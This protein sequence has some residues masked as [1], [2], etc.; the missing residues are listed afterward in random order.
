MSLDEMLEVVAK[1]G[2]CHKDCVRWYSWPTVFGDTSGPMGGYGGQMMTEFQV[3]AFEANGV[4]LKCCAGVWRHW[5][6]EFQGRW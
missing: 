2:G 4:M 5:N 6:G 3:Y 1:K